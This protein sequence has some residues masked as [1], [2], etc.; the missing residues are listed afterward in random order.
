MMNLQKPLTYLELGNMEPQQFLNKV[1]SHCHA[2]APMHPDALMAVVS[3]LTYLSR[4][5]NLRQ[6]ERDTAAELANSLA[7]AAISSFGKE[8]E[9]SRNLIHTVNSIMNHG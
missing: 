2:G 4:D 1:L 8:S 7:N 9:F 5:L 6:T 3:R